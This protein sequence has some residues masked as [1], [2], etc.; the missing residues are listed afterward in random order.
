MD[1][2]W[3]ERREDVVAALRVLAAE[4]PAL[5]VVGRDPRFPDLT[6]AVHWL[7]DDT[8]WDSEDPVA[9]VGTILRDG[10]EAEVIRAV[11][12]AVVLVS[13]R[14]GAAASDAAWF[15]DRGWC[16]VRRLAAE[17]LSCLAP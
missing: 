9:S 17:A 16:E 7:V 14:Q 4:A 3:P 5:G 1:V 8:S 15:G 2:A 6:N 12:A 13:D 10:A 11:V